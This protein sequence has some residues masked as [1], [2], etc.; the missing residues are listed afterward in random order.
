MTHGSSMPGEPVFILDAP[1][2]HRVRPGKRH[3]F[4][5]LAL[6]IPDGSGA[7]V[8]RTVV[9]RESGTV[10]LEAAVDRESEDVARILPSIAGAGRC[11]FA[12]ILSVDAATYTLHGRFEEGAEV[13]L[14]VFDTAGA[15]DARVML[16]GAG[17]L[18]VPPASLL[19]RTQGGDDAEAYRDSIISAHH[20]LRT[21][22]T[23]SGVDPARV[24]RVLDIGCGTGRLLA[25]WHLDDR[26]RELTG[27]DIDRECMAWTAAHLPGVAQWH[28]SDIRP[29]LPFSSGSF[30]LVQLASVFTHLSIELQ[31][32][33]VRELARLARPG[34]AVVVTLHGEPYAW[35]LDDAQR[36]RLAT[37]GHVEQPAGEE[38]SGGYRAF[39]EPGFARQL[40]R[41]SFS[42]VDFYPRGQPAFPPRQFPMASLQDVYILHV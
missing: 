1:H 29:P 32:A 40:F 33:W 34:G 25:G 22:L 18:P 7:R 10:C 15:P 41:Q 26:S 3:Q 4:R 31:E 37:G 27:V 2:Y 28:A 35:I 6:A 19:T 20:M 14:F 17:A 30:D 5:G 12:F 23:S 39:H 11:R 24:G 38:G 16:D 36:R 42:R 21:L 9:V 13:P 8:I